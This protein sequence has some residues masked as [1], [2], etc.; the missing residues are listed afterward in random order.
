MHFIELQT[1]AGTKLTLYAN[2]VRGVESKPYGCDVQWLI[3]EAIAKVECSTDYQA[4]VD[5]WKWDGA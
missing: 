3:G 1:K 5:A 4:V 2:D